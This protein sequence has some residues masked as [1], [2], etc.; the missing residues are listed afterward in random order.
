[1]NLYHRSLYVLRSYRYLGALEAEIRQRLGLG[2]NTVSFSRES[3]F[4]WRQ[5]A[6][7]LGTVKWVYI[8][9]LGG[10]LLAFL[11]GRMYYDAR[12]SSPW[13]VLVDVAVSVPTLLYFAAYAASSVGLDKEASR[14]DM[15]AAR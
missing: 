10:L 2:T 7:L 9:L 4:Y 8:V 1:V 13:F 11:G 6:F 14:A 5:R 15:P 3:T 12:Y